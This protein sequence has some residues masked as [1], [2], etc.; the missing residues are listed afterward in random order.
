MQLGFSIVTGNLSSNLTIEAKGP[1]PDKF[2]EN[3]LLLFDQKGNF[4]RSVWDKSK[5][6]SDFDNYRDE[7]WMF[8]SSQTLFYRDTQFSDTLFRLT[9]KLEPEPYLILNNL[10]ETADPASAPQRGPESSA[11]VKINNFLILNN[12]I[13]VSGRKEKALFY[14]VNRTTQEVVYSEKLTDDLLGLH[15]AFDGVTENSSHMMQL[16]FLDVYRENPDILFQT[17]KPVNP[18]VQARL[19]QAIKEADDE[20]QVI[21]VFYKVNAQ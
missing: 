10:P 20:V 8:E 6:Q 1:D 5:D 12:F 19:R 16:I 2:D 7:N 18:A 21:L 13:L 17:D 15:A 4:L 9:K 11:S 3:R 14:Q